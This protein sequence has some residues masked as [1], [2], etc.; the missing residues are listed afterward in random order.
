MVTFHNFQR[1][2]TPKCLRFFG[3]TRTSHTHPGTFHKTYGN[4]QPICANPLVSTHITSKK[5]MECG[6]SGFFRGE[7]TGKSKSG[8]QKTLG[9]D[10][11]FYQVLAFKWNPCGKAGSQSVE[12]KLFTPK[13]YN[14]NFSMLAA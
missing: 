10:G 2:I 12:P 13:R 6:I 14:D 1:S 7:K 4:S 11:E 3:P 5:A 8:T 9:L